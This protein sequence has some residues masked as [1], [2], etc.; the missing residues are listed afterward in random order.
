[1][2]TKVCVLSLL[3]AVM[4]AGATDIPPAPESP[5]FGQ[6]GEAIF[7]T[8]V[9][10]KH[11]KKSED[12]SQGG[13][14]HVFFTAWIPDGVKRVRGIYHTPFNLDTVEK[15]HSRAMAANWGLA[16]VGGNF[17]RVHKEDFAPSLLAG[18]R[19]LAV[20]SGHPALADAPM[21]ISGMSAGAGMSVTLAE[22]LPERT[23]ACAL[24]CLEVGPATANT[25]DIP[26]MTIFGEK[27]GRQMEQLAAKLPQQRAAFDARWAIA[28]QW[29]RKHEWAKANHL[30][31]TFF[32]EVLR[33][34]LPDGATSL[35]PCDTLQTWFGNPATWGERPADIAPA[36]EFTG[37]NAKSCWLPGPETARVWQA[38][39]VRKPQLRITSPEPQGDGKPLAIYTPD[40]DIL[41]RADCDAALTGSQ[42]TLFDRTTRLAT[43]NITAGKAEIRAGKLPPGLHTFILQAES[44]DGSLTLSHPVS[45][46][47]QRAVTDSKK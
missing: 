32:D 28:P 12:R 24:V 7:S 34:R 40:D 46:L 45:V 33:Q 25:R 8:A 43:A 21:L 14:N 27:D 47:V 16:I 17:M 2:K 1:M 36:A 37:D 42:V 41:I 5:K 9:A 31:W 18:L 29:G 3:L 38:F 10:L 26:M 22:A 30:L 19:D 4:S 13:T 11:P 15:A 20:K 6:P 23:I 35:R 39:A 44:A